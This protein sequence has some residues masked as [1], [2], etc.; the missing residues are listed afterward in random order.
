MITS[1]KGL[2]WLLREQVKTNKK[3]LEKMTKYDRRF[4]KGY[5]AGAEDTIKMIDSYDFVSEKEFK[6][7]KKKQLERESL[8]G[9]G[10]LV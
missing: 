7:L 8:Q 9:K 5:I 6:Q 4:F 2:L 1:K 3:D 10:V